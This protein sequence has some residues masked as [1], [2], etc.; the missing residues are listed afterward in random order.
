MSRALTPDSEDRHPRQ[1]PLQTQDEVRAAMRAAA[2]MQRDVIVAAVVC[3]R[4]MPDLTQI[5]PLASISRSTGA[6]A[7]R[8]T[9]RSLSVSG[10]GCRTRSRER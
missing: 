4:L 5:A 8:I 6:T 3:G 2:L 10:R 1:S 7:L 9:L